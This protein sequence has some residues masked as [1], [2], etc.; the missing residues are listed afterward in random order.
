MDRS[1]SC[2][3]GCDHRPQASVGWTLANTCDVGQAGWGRVGTSPGPTD[4]SASPALQL[5]KAASLPGPLCLLTWPPLCPSL[6]CALAS[7]VPQPPAPASPVPRSPVL[8]SLRPCLP[9]APAS[10]PRLPC[11]LASL[12][13]YLTPPHGCSGRALLSACTNALAPA[14]FSERAAPVPGQIGCSLSLGPCASPSENPDCA[15]KVNLEWARCS[16]VPSHPGLG[17]PP[18][19]HLGSHSPCFT[20]SPCSSARA[21][22]VT[23]GLSAH[24]PRPPQRCCCCCCHLGSSLM[25]LHPPPTIISSQSYLA[26]L[27]ASLVLNTQAHPPQGLCTCWVSARGLFS[28][29]S[30]LPEPLCLVLPDHRPPY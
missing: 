22:G 8:A 4:F 27:A 21:S 5:L 28:Q 7:P 20:G 11:S 26:T 17:P 29:D 14:H 1:L 16:R 25:C 9:C 13:T 23:L 24:T 19:W 6:P 3:G 30:L 2:P 10:C 18:P 12:S 15:A